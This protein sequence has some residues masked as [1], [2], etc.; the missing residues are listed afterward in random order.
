MFTSSSLLGTAEAGWVA[1]FYIP[2]SRYLAAILCPNSERMVTEQI[3]TTL[4]CRSWSH[5]SIFFYTIC[6]EP[7]A[8]VY[9]SEVLKALVLHAFFPNQIYFVV[10][11]F[12]CSFLLD[13]RSKSVLEVVDVKCS[14]T[15]HFLSAKRSSFCRRGRVSSGNVWFH[16]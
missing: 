10:V 8:L 14:P 1:S 12:F 16:F 15:G 13:C 2:L 4:P 5:L 3:S 11:V 7:L 9:L 6:I